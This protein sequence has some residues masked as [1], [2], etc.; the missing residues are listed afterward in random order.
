M[1]Y[2]NDY[3]PPPPPP[4]DVTRDAQQFTPPEEYDLNFV[5]GPIRTLKSDKVELRPFIVRSL[6]YPLRIPADSP[7]GT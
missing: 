7:D 4:D 5:L 2:R 6:Q 1:M 3:K